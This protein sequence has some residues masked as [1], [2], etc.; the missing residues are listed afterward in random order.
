MK[1]II[2]LA[3]FVFLLSPILANAA[4][5]ASASGNVSEG[6]WLQTPLGNTAGTAY[7]N[8]INNT[9]S[10]ATV[11]PELWDYK[12]NDQLICADFVTVS[13]GQNG[14]CSGSSS[15]SDDYYAKGRFTSGPS[16]GNITVQ[17]TNTNPGE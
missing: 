8:V 2:G 5:L 15:S 3:M 11:N 1:K 14:F 10:S 4:V 9:G 17:L 7:S 13:N 16:S 6:V 12:V